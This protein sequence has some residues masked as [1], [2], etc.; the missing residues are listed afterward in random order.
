VQQVLDVALAWAVLNKHF[1][2]AGFL[3]AHGADVNTDWATH[4]PAS[5]LHECAVHGDF[6]GARFLIAHGVDLT[7][8][9][10]RWK[11]TAAGWAWSAARETDEVSGRRGPTGLVV[12]LSS[13]LSEL[14]NV[15]V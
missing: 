4:E 5:I 13:V 12:F 1:Q 2:V 11:G 14:F 6:E 15:V 3:L 7:I 9:N 10:H 8:R